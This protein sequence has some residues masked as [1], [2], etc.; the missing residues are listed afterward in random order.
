MRHHG[1]LMGLMGGAPTVALAASTHKTAG[2]LEL[3]APGVSLTPDGADVAEAVREAEGRRELFGDIAS[4]LRGGALALPFARLAS[5]LGVCDSPWMEGPRSV[6]TTREAQAC[7]AGVLRVFGPAACVLVGPA[8]GKVRRALAEQGCVVRGEAGAQQDDVVVVSDAP[9]EPGIGDRLR[10]WASPGRGVV[11]CVRDNGQRSVSEWVRLAA[12]AGLV[13]HLRWRLAVSEHDE[14][15]RGGLRTLAFV[16]GRGAQGGVLRDAARRSLDAYCAGFVRPR[17]TAI[18][19]GRD[20]TRRAEAVRALVPALVRPAEQLDQGTGESDACVIELD[21][22]DS[23]SALA[24]VLRRADRRLLPGGRVVLLIEACGD[25]GGALAQVAKALGGVERSDGEPVFLAEHACVQGFGDAPGAALGTREFAVDAGGKPTGAMPGGSALAVVL[26][27]DPTG[28]GK[29]A[30]AEAIFGQPVGVAGANLTAFA[31]DYDNPWLPASLVIM[32]YRASGG[33]V[34]RLLAERTLRTAR[35]GSADQGAALCVKAYRMLEGDSP[36]REAVGEI[37]RMIAAFDATAD[38][39]PTAHRWR[40][41]NWYVLG[42]LH[43]AVGEAARAR[44]AYERC[45]ALDVLVYSPLLAT[46]TIDAR[47]RLGALALAMGERSRAHGHFRA[48]VEAARAAAKA[49]WV[50]VVGAA[51][52]PLPFGLRELGEVLD[53]GARCAA[54]LWWSGPGERAWEDAR[55]WTRAQNESRSAE[56]S[57]AA[58]T[59]TANRW[60]ADRLEATEQELDVCRRSARGEAQARVRAESLLARVEEVQ[61]AAA[62][63]EAGKRWLEEHARAWRSEHEAAERT[64]GELRA[65]CE[66][67][68]AGKAHALA[69]AESWRSAH[70]QAE[71]SVAELREWAKVLES[72]R[73]GLAT[74]SAELR[75]ALEHERAALVTARTELDA[76]RAELGASR[77]ES[78]KLSGALVREQERAGLAE[79]ALGELHAASLPRIAAWRLRAWWKRRFRK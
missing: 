33:D 62:E 2:T 72:T 51:E 66:A 3:V 28:A 13:P 30:R 27:K 58:D 74:R 67:L 11:L 59:L 60:L 29:D 63:L 42:R 69:Q 73:D 44:T 79:R 49:D 26:M 61:R 57:L 53:A 48:G 55:A 46:K 68:E 45:A 75:A 36:T 6:I 10:R 12:D 47:Y 71:A 43:Q 9:I 8:D 31:R 37:D 18:V 32:G 38:A 20:A 15:R 56:Q 16:P 52:D 78:E 14:L 77:A 4:R 24:G 40:I 50:N 19:C 70:G 1:V 17:T 54:M 22:G 23:A 21:A 65:W 76:S 5:M 7:A 64:I 25:C 39:T 35:P 34:L 41:S